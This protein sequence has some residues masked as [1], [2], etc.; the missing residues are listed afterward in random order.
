MEQRVDVSVVVPTY[1]NEAGYAQTLSALA[2][3][4]LSADRFE[5]IFVD[6]GSHGGTPKELTAAIEEVPFSL[7]VLTTGTN[8]GGPA[9]P[10][11][12]GW[13]AA[14]APIIAFLDDDCI[15]D[16]RWLESGLDAIGVGAHIGVVQGRTIAPPGVDL[17]ALDR[18]YVYRLILE[19]SPWFEAAN[20]FYRKDALE[21]AGGFNETIGTWG[22][23]TDLGWKV[24][25][26]GWER[27][28][29]VDAL[30]TH[31]VERR[32]WRYW[33]RFGLKEQ[34]IVR[35]GVEHPQFREE[36]F[37]RSWAVRRDD[38]AFAAAV[39]GLAASA[40]WA[41]AA[42]ALLPYAWWRRPK[43][44]HGRIASQSVE[45][46]IA[47]IARCIGHATGSVRARTLVL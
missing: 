34:N 12:M 37:W 23:D 10:R 6:D 36:A 33:F 14:S 44:R 39:V 28:F 25:E 26:A 2:S 16:R 4:S 21:Q 40:A 35:L 8:S 17:L 41:P 45:I 27:A 29:A 5:V 9:I 22:E 46:L 11:N 13:R 18:Y 7:K 20:I 3:Q 24:L 19:P 31:A 38:A 32:D 1:N 47:D 15:P 43:V 30:A 42:L